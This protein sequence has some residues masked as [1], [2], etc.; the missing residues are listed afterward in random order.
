MFPEKNILLLQKINALL[1]HVDRREPSA[2]LCKHCTYVNETEFSFCTN[3]GYPL[4]NSLL[5]DV[6]HKRIRQRTN[7]LFKA[8]SSVMFARIVLYVI[9]SF[10]F[11]GIFFIFAE[12]SRKYLVVLLALML[13]GLFFFLAFW[14]RKNPFTA[15]LTAFIVLIAFSAINIFS[16]LVQSFTTLAGVTGML[17]CLVLLFVM[18]RGV[19]AAYR[20]NLINEEL[21]VKI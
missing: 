19:Q 2:V 8:E 5:E 17:L 6:F 7:I 14:S 13:S 20:I 4:Q 1:P 15:L 21:Q 12:N 9:G 18:L 11:M 16:S 3:C 10:L